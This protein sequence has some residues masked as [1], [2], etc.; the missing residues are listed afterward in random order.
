[1]VHSAYGSQ[2]ENQNKKE[3]QENLSRESGEEA[4]PQ[5]IKTE[6]RFIRGEA[7]QQTACSRKALCEHPPQK[8]SHRAK[9]NTARKE[10]DRR[11]RDV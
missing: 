1:M 5:E 3:Q 9:K 11:L 2:K 10:P 8:N 7:R 6:K 4:C